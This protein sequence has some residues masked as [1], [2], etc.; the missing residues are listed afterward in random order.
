MRSLATVLALVALLG[1]MAYT[2]PSMEDFSNFVRQEVMKESQKEVKGHLGQFMSSMIGS[3][4]GGLVSTQTLRTDYLFLSTYTL[5]L[6]D[7]RIKALGIFRNFVLLE[8]PDLKRYK[9]GEV[10][11]R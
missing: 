3:I 6:G 1:L 5:P 8:K 4:A 7:E 2:N 11:A 9:R 10:P